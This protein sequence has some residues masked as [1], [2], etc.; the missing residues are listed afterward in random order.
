MK[1]TSGKKAKV[2]A[3]V[4]P[5]ASGKTSLS[6]QLAKAFGGEVVSADSRQVYRGLDLG[7]GKVT[8][9][10][11]DSIPHHLLDVADP[12]HAYTV[13]EYVRDAAETITDIVNRQRLPIIVGGTFL[14]IDTLLGAV[15]TSPVAPNP[16]LRTE[17]DALTTHD[18]VAR[19]EKF[20]SARTHSIDRNNRR[21][22]IRA[23]EI[24]EA[25]GYIP[26]TVTTEPYMVLKIGISISKDTLA[27]NIH[28]RL[29]DRLARGM[30][31]E[32][33]H[34]HENG[35]T[36]ER[37]DDFGLEYRYISRY[38]R[39]QITYEKMNEEIETKSRQYAKRQMTW[40]KRDNEIVWVEPGEVEKAQT[41]VRDF[42]G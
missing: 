11:M 38:L 25:L 30:I 26:E 20:D 31:T 19:L 8:L 5:T 9:E 28:N 39:G 1:E 2:I 33:E 12:S 18:L 35:L 13:H 40:L 42:L 21:R 27:Q 41:I 6:I 7:T 14:Y 15:S 37:L 29:V 23:I 34:L 10:E 16:A 4:G 17:L 36:Y 22:L 32:V 3:I 24:T